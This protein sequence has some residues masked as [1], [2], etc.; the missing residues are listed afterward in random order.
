M[1]HV[2]S[3]PRQRLCRW[4]GQYFTAEVKTRPPEFCK[5]EHHK[6]ALADRKAKQ[7]AAAKAPEPVKIARKQEQPARCPVCGA[8]LLYPGAP[9][10]SRRCFYERLHIQGPLLT[11]GIS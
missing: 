5:P 7:R 4:C 9:C 10:L 1:K 2:T 8:F 11:A 3:R 6:A